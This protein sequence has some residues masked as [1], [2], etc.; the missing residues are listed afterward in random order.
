[1]Q[2][3]ESPQPVVQAPAVRPVPVLI[4]G[5]FLSCAGLA[6][7]VCEDLAEHLGQSGWPVTTTSRKL[8]RIPRLA[9]MLSTVWRT[10]HRYK[11]AQVDVYS[12]AAFF[13]AEA[14]CLM[15]RRAHKPYVL[16]LHG[17]NLPAFAGKR[18]ARIRRLLGSAAAVT[19]PSSYLREQMS[20]YRPDTIVIPNPVEIANYSYRQ[21]SRPRP[22]IVWVRSFHSIYNPA[23]A[24]SAVSRLIPSLPDLH[25]TMVGPDKNDGTW[26]SAQHQALQPPLPQHV[27]FTGGVP[28]SRI[29]GYLS[30]N[31]IF[32]NTSNV[33]NTPVSIIEAM[34]CGLCIISTNVG[35]IPYL[36]K[37]EHN[38]LL[39]PP[40]DPIAMSNAIERILNEPDLAERISGNARNLAESFDW[41]TLLPRWQA[42]LAS[43]SSARK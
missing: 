34:A 31:D 3:A 24:L 29:P 2:T 33:D 23:L 42:L 16:T 41:G 36:L 8:G 22:A 1:M 9:D 40:D 18:A 26:A 32:I 6:R 5:N 4:V 17:G 35:G 21:R 43:I 11:A 7:G 12:G 38:A 39:V 30:S 10:R 15:L 20:A 13:W 37:N 14:V 28:K 27:T 19:A 25:L